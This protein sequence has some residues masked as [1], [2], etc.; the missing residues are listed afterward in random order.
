[1]HDEMKAIQA[2]AVDRS[3]RPTPQARK[4]IVKVYGPLSESQARQIQ[5]QGA[6][7]P[8]RQQGEHLPVQ[9]R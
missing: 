2:Q 1:M 9:K 8:P 4:G 7:A 5:R 6:I 3:G